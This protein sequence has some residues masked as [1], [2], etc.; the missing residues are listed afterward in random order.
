MKIKVSTTNLK[1]GMYVQDLDCA[2]VDTPFLFQGFTIADNSEIKQL[3]DHCQYV[4]IDNERGDD[5]DSHLLDFD[6]AKV[7]NN[8]KKPS[9][10][11]DNTALEE[12]ED[13]KIL[14]AKRHTVYEDTQS[15]EDELQYA[16]Q[17]HVELQKLIT[18]I[19]QDV[20]L[21]NK[22]N[23]EKIKQ[24]T[25]GMIES[26]VRNPDAFTWLTRLKNV[27]SYTYTHAIDSSILGVAFGR[28]LGL[29]KPELQD[30]AL[31]LMFADT[32]KV[33]VSQELLTK[34][35]H[36]TET[37]FNEIKKHVDFSY[38]V[39]KETEN[40]SN[41]SLQ[42]IYCHHERHDGKGYPRGLAGNKIPVFARMA[43]I[44][45]CY[46]AITSDRVYN[47][48]ISQH[49]A[50]R[51][52]FKWRNINFQEELVEQFI[53]CLGVYPT[54]SLVELTTGQVGV[55]LS[56]NRVR[57]LKP[58]VMLILNANK[59]AYGISPTLDLIKDTEDKDGNPIEILRA[60]EPSVYG[61]DPNT[62]YL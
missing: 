21:G 20:Q 45:D 12:D 42:I 3:C 35:E 47:K 44:V 10:K 49:E 24:A 19:M 18:N 25:D 7:E 9:P 50:V 33:K 48:A 39:A 31:G 46:D 61:I 58:K 37:E 57:S 16:K 32:G 53:Q 60:I 51:K 5:V 36:L 30:I 56:Q 26:I 2:W 8:Q 41:R 34:P 4:Y 13:G 54:G 15:L 29:S 1:L 14:L 23:L 6:T 38:E 27:D 59:E 28:H 62:F 17:A 22:L 11:L 43:S 40:L 55:I 52:L